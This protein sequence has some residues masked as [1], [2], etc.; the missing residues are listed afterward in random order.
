MR[1]SVLVKK[2]FEG[3]VFVDEHKVHFTVKSFQLM[4][5]KINSYNDVMI[6]FGMTLVNNSLLSCRFIIINFFKT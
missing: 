4:Y 3:G 1:Q 2:V 6:H 5:R